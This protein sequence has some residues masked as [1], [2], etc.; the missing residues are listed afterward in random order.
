LQGIEDTLQSSLARAALPYANKNFQTPRHW[1]CKVSW[2]N[3]LCWGPDQ[4]VLVTAPACPFCLLFFSFFF[5]RAVVG[6]F[7]L[8]L[9]L[10]ITAQ[11]SRTIL[12]D[13]VRSRQL[14]SI[15][16]THWPQGDLYKSHSKHRTKTNNLWQHRRKRGPKTPIYQSQGTYLSIYDIHL[17]HRSVKRKSDSSSKIRTLLT[18]TTP[19][20]LLFSHL[21]KVNAK[22]FLLGV[23]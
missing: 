3:E 14:L 2:Y 15:Q 6:E 21:I 4:A 19:K 18:A 8:L 23:W 1:D 5:G 13:L 11:R 22:Y 16:A 9:R 7:A 17:T 10:E 12:I 20:S